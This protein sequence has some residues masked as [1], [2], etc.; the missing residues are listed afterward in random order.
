MT[1]I[2]NATIAD[3]QIISYAMKGVLKESI[4]GFTIPSTVAH[5]FLTV[6]DRNTGKSRY[7]TPSPQILSVPPR[8]TPETGPAVVMDRPGNMP[9]FR[10]R[11]DR[12]VMDFNNEFPSIVEHGHM[13]MAALINSAG[14]RIFREAIFHLPK[15]E[16]KALTAKFHFLI[17]EKIRCIPINGQHAQLA[18]DL[19][20]SLIASGVN[21]KANFRNSLNDMIILATAL[22]S[23]SSLWTEDDL[24]ANFA[25]R[26][27]E[28]DVSFRDGVYRIE[29]PERS[30][31][32]QKSRESKGYVNTGW[33]FALHRIPPPATATTHG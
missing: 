24:L 21:L 11:T 25:K 9:R 15:K 3:T 33:R 5:E 32:R 26:H 4:A 8:V 28:P 13:G 23:K 14:D 30:S 27:L 17:E 29:F 19:L 20:R 18:F 22:K 6:R 10:N 7:F 16:K 2:P 12:L 1:D 31:E